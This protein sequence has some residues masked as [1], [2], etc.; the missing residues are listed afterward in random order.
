M[1]NLFARKCRTFF[2]CAGR[3]HIEQEQKQ[4]WANRKDRN[5]TPTAKKQKNFFFYF[6]LILNYRI[7][8]HELLTH[9]ITMWAFAEVELIH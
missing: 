2:L 5:C 1:E 7:F 6:V 4:H 8:A 3:I 9:I